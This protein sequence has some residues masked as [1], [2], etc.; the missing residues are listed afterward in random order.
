MSCFKRK[1]NTT[2]KTK[3]KL[4]PPFLFSLLLI[5]Y[6]IVWGFFILLYFFI[7]RKHIC[8]VFI[9][10]C[11]NSAQNKIS[12]SRIC[13]NKDD[14]VRLVSL[15]FWKS[16]NNYFLFNTTDKLLKYVIQQFAKVLPND[17]GGRKSFVQCGG[18][19]K[20][21]EMKANDNSQELLEYLNT[22]NN[23]FP[24]ELVQYY[25]PNYSNELLKRLEE[26]D[27]HAK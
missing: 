2:K 23:C 15:F 6:N 27:G 12:S 21:Q 5:W 11:L 22:I 8:L 20:V 10:N 1:K 19:Q 25:S 26:Y 14:K 3:K 24:P 4:F 13:N 18:L 16:V 9:D 17:Q 7:R